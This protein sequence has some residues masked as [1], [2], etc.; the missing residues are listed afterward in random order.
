[1]ENNIYIGITGKEKDR[2]LFVSFNGQLFIK[3]CD[4][5]VQV[6]YWSKHFFNGLMASLP[7]ETLLIEP[8]MKAYTGKLKD[9]SRVIGFNLTP[10]K[11]ATYTAKVIGNKITDIKPI[12][13]GARPIVCQATMIEIAKKLIKHSYLE[14]VTK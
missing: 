10:P 6:A 4:D 3:Q 5:W 7:I 9:T 13:I 2:E 1:M 14:P 11:H 12:E 8:K